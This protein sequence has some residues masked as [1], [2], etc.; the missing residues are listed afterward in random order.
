MNSRRRK[1]LAIAVLTLVLT[2][3]TL[4]TAVS[5]TGSQEGAPTGSEVPKD[6]KFGRLP[7]I[8]LVIMDDIGI[9][10]W[11]LFGYGGETP[12][13]TPN[14]DAI[15]DGGVRFH[16]MWSMPACSN[17]R[18]ALF[19]GRYPFR[20]NVLTALGNNDLANYMVNPNEI[21]LPRLLKQRG[22]KSALFG[23]FHLGIQ[24]NDPYGY[25][26]VQA[27]GF[28]YFDGW[29]DATGDPSSIDTT[30]GG[31]S[32]TGT[33]SCGFVRD[34]A[35]P[36]GANTGAC[37]AGD[38][39]CSVITK[40]GAEAPGRV[41]RDSGGI[42]DP[43]HTCSSP[44]PGYVNFSTL[45]G[46]YVSPLVINQEDGT[47]EQVPPTDIRARTYR[48]IELVDTAIAWVKQQPADQ[49]WMA[50]LSFATAH[51]PLMQPPSQ[52]LPST[53][54]DSSNLNCQS[55]SGDSTTGGR[56]SNNP[57][58]ITAEQRTISNEMEEA[59]DFE[60]GR[61]MTATG[62]AAS[63]PNG[64]L[65]YNPQN[66]NTYVI[67]I[68]DN[69]SLGAV[70]KLP[71]DSKRAKSTAY[72]T[73]V[74]VPAIVSGPGVVKPGR[75]TDAMV[76]IVDLYQLVGELAG[77]NVQSSVPSILDSRPMLPY[78]TNPNQPSIRT[79]NYT[80][81]GTNQHANGAINGPCVYGGTSCTQIAPTKGVCEDNS[82]VW[83]GPG[84]DLGSAGVPSTG[85]ALCCDVAVWQHDHNYTPMVNSIYPL[86]AYAMRNDHYKLVINKYQSYNATTDACAATTSTEFYEINEDVPIPKLDTQDSNLLANGNTLTGVQKANFDL[87][88]AR[89]NR[90]RASQPACPGDINLDGVVNEGDV[91]QWS[92]FQA[93]SMGSSWADLDQDGLTD[94]TDLDIIEQ[95]F[96]PCPKAGPGGGLAAH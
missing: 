22:Y 9:D 88:M 93:L 73:G 86:Q 77:I 54:P 80:E 33:W 44:P 25:S 31:V 10:Q 40:I 83:W 95:N 58:C 48:A 14:I 82:G 71:F 51:T 38:G 74:W 63:G 36:G 49:P 3:P 55:G 37:Y 32:P 72:Q 21:T 46:H 1:E 11:S 61:F 57:N 5:R 24:S 96:G 29:L 16:N 59:L 76:N 17:G 43:N 56:C 91:E 50:V 20:T 66:S 64:Q 35:A 4:A 75:Q 6:A 78:L 89:L 13:A 81:I 70:V 67:F 53:E 68:T 12:A 26:M 34:A 28:D 19:T 27:L 7:N 69:G 39:T 42:F 60:V 8:V 30:A 90:L 2:L 45:S 94:D 87:L 85:F 62:L 52:T 18:A 84:N 23:K 47:V 79:T 65:I 15:A 92:M 41:C